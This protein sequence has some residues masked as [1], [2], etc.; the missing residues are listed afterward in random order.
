MG[1]ITKNIGDAITR[2]NA[3]RKRIWSNYTGKIGNQTSVII[4]NMFDEL[5]AFWGFFARGFSRKC[6]HW[7]GNF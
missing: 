2:K 1:T 7:R 6:L 3:G 5:I 4:R